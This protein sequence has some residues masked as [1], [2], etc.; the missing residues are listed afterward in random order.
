MAEVSIT[1][2]DGAEQEKVVNR[3]SP[4]FQSR[5]TF[6]VDSALQKS[7]RKDKQS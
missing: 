6:R 2:K 4:V 5:R 3:T 7:S 1:L